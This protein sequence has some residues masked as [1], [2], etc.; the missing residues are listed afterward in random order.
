MYLIIYF[1][2]LFIYFSICIDNF[3]VPELSVKHYYKYRSTSMNFSFNL[4]NSPLYLSISI[5]CYSPF[6]ADNVLIK[7]MILVQ[8]SSS[9]PLLRTNH[10]LPL[11][12][13]NLRLTTS[14]NYF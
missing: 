8:P 1:S 11:Y 3:F 5:N 2:I 9:Y 7:F 6:F 12:R 10:L 14:Y 13:K 4:D